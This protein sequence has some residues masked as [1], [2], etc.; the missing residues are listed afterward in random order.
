M[1][2]VPGDTVVIA[3]VNAICCVIFI[4]KFTPPKIEIDFVVAGKV[5]DQDKCSPRVVAAIN[6][7]IQECAVRAFVWGSGTNSYPALIS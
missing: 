4:V 7:I 1:N 6:R 3:D 2:L 5:Q